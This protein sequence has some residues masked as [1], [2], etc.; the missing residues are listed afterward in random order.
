M[1]SREPIVNAP[2]VVTWTLG[3]LFIIHLVLWLLPETE[4]LDILVQAA[5]IPQRYGAGLLHMHD[6]LVAITSLL[7]HQLVHWDWMHLLINSAWLLAFGSAVAARIGAIRFVVFSI[8]CGIA[9]AV[10]FILMHL[11]DQTLMIGAS[12]ALSGLM[13]GA[14]RFLFSSIDRGGP[15]TFRDKAQM[16]PRMSITATFRDRRA[17][18]AIGFWI[19][20]NFLTALAAP[21][22]TSAGGIAW[23]A[24]LGGFAFGFLAFGAFD[25]VPA[26]TPETT[27][28]I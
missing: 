23:E 24:H 25:P 9:G 12:G 18:I 17:A 27:W 8:L 14:F 11:H 22:F 7:T 6:G 4:R 3:L 16:V 19:G 21:L 13:G 1:S 20:V 15:N 26:N 28:D 2:A 10:T 5:V